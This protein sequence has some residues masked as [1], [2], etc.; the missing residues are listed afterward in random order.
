VDLLHVPLCRHDHGLKHAEAGG[1]ASP[2][3]ATSFRPIH[4]PLRLAADPIVVLAI[5]AVNVLAHD[6]DGSPHVCGSVAASAFAVDVAGDRDAGT[7]VVRVALGCSSWRWRFLWGWR[8]R[9][10][11]GWRWR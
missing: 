1:W 11:W 8:F 7:R 10:L 9:F 6:G 4:L 3:P 5:E 2:S